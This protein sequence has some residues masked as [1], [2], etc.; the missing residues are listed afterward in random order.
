MIKYHFMK[1][2]LLFFDLDDT[3][4]RNPMVDWVFPKIFNHF[5]EFHPELTD[6][7]LWD[8]INSILRPRY[9]EKKVESFDWDDLVTRVAKKYNVPFEWDV[10]SLIAEG[11]HPPYLRILDHVRDGL[12]TLR[13][14]NRYRMV[15]GT[16]GHWPYQRPSVEALGL[17]QYFDGVITPDKVGCLKGCP[18]FYQGAL[19]DSKLQITIGDQYDADVEDPMKLG[20][21]A[22]WIPITMPKE[23]SLE[24]TPFERAEVLTIPEG[25]TQRPD[26]I[27]RDF[28]ELP[29][30]IEGIEQKHL[31]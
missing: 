31:S 2:T 12:A 18:E 10:A 23:C 25:F 1:P 20:F 13:Q 26:A 8:E 7:K 28:R 15:I 17:L 27:I 6:E 9:R 14:S 22:V 21:R 11:A 16:N 29:A 3:C 19:E 5:R 24:M 4:M 30:A